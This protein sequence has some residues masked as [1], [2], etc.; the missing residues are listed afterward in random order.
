MRAAVA[1]AIG[2]LV[3]IASWPTTRLVGVDYV[4]GRERVP[5]WKKASEFVERDSRLRQAS[6]EVL[7]GVTGS[8]A[9]ATAALAWTRSTIRH[10]PAGLPVIDDHITSIIERGYGEADQLADVFSTLLTYD[11]VPAYWRAFGKSPN[12]LPVSFVEIDAAWRMFDVARGLAFRN[13]RGQLAAI[14]EIAG[15]LTI[16]ER[17]LHEAGIADPQR[18]LSFF[19]G[20][21]ASP[22][23]RVLRAELQMP[24]R[25]LTFELRKVMGA[26]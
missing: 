10:A 7:G 22:P 24:W 12:V 3:A 5:L 6:R 8:E 21:R 26:P 14:E 25:R 20:F 15:D 23:P 13:Q 16:V 4:V 1:G 2:V 17:A 19:R 18:Y 9:K 11:G